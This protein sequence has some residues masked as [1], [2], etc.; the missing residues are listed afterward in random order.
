MLNKLK[1][2]MCCGRE[3]LI[4]CDHTPD[5]RPWFYLMCCNRSCPNKT[6]SLY[7]SE[8]EAIEAW[9]RRAGEE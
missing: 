4:Y 8:R 9:N 1:P 6:K 2:R 3:P 7:Q 5:S